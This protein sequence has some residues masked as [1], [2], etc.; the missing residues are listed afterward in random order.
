M[1]PW[2]LRL[3]S[4]IC[5]NFSL[6]ACAPLAYARLNHRSP[7]QRARRR[8]K[9]R[10]DRG[11]MSFVV[12]MASRLMIFIV[13]F[14]AKLN[15]IKSYGADIC[16]Y[17]LILLFHLCHF[18]IFCFFIWLRLQLIP[19]E[20]LVVLDWPARRLRL[21]EKLEMLENLERLESPGRFK[22]GISGVFPMIKNVTSFWH[23][24]LSMDAFAK[25]AEWV[26]LFIF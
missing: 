17:M 10:W 25:V 6:S 19:A 21:W 7:T 15:L 24:V 3:S 12:G 11:S 20:N 22:F 23:S 13:S 16:W 18:C 8:A 5:C 2:G 4:R 1:K 14:L 26:L 9:T